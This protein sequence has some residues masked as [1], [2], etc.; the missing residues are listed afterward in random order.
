MSYMI[1]IE[2]KLH[3]DA[4]SAISFMITSS[5]WGILGAWVLQALDMRYDTQT[6]T[7]LED[8]KRITYRVV[9]A[10]AMKKEPTT[11]KVRLV[12]LKKL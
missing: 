8:K 4:N 10:P 12:K 9:P 6:N 7:Q 5:I 1:G 11:R 3:I 2:E